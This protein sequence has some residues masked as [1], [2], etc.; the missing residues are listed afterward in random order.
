MAVNQNNYP[1]GMDTD[2][3]GMPIPKVSID[4]QGRASVNA[5]T[6]TG[7]GLQ[8]NGNYVY[9]GSTWDR[10]RSAGGLD[11]MPA[12]GMFAIAPYLYNGATFDRLRGVGGAMNI[13]QTGRNYQEVQ[14]V[15]LAILDTLLHTGTVQNVNTLTGNTNIM[16]DNPSD[17]AVTVTLYVKNLLGRNFQVW[18]GSIPNAGQK[19]LTDSDIPVLRTPLYQMSAN[20]QYTV[21]PT[22]GTLAV[23]FG[24]VQA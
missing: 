8:A 19:I 22:T 24:G 12:T 17:Q 5:D 9:N 20:A 1:V 6:V 3:N 21:A 11:A 10:V 4:G 15:N 18:T 16:I 2:G 23:T 13:I 14:L 7:S